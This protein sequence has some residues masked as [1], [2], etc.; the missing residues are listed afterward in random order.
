MTALRNSLRTGPQHARARSLAVLASIIGRKHGINVVFRNG[1]SASTDGKTIYL[2]ILSAN[3]SEEDAIL[4]EGLMD[5][6]AGHCRF[7]DFEFVRNNGVQAQLRSHALIFPTWNTFEDVWMEREQSKV[8]PG[9]FRNIKKSI[10][11]MIDRGLYAAPSEGKTTAADGMRGF[12]LH[13]LLGRLYDNKRMQEFGDLHREALVNVIGKSLTADIWQTALEIDSVK[14]TQDAFALALRIF[15]MIKSELANE[16][17][18]KRSSQ[19]K[20]DALDQILNIKPSGGDIGDMIQAALNANGV[21]DANPDVPQLT[22]LR[23]APASESNLL[24][25]PDLAAL[26]KPIASKLGSRLEV[27]LETKTQEATSFKRSGRKL[28]SGR[29]VGLTLGNLSAFVSREE[30]EGLDTAITILGDFSGSMYPILEEDDIHQ[31]PHVVTKTSMLAI[32]DVLERFEVPFSIIAYGND[33]WEIKSFEAP[34]RKSKALLNQDQ[35]GLTYTAEALLKVAERMALRKETR[36]LVLLLTDGDSRENALVIPAM[37]EMA[38]LGIE[39]ACIFIGASGT[40]LQ[41]LM[42]YEGYPVQRVSSIDALPQ[43]MF[44][45]IRNAV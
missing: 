17:Q 35:M 6:E 43:V 39:F 25:M 26:A 13:A 38:N 40:A 29:V 2:P 24:Y 12:L 22:Q 4:V 31:S 18:K 15:A 7:T 41:T 23:C 11:V 30:G 19:K 9:C 37:N 33:I 21:T 16:D 32:G 34:W 8:Y 28:A 1:A 5:H 45:A 42:T 10:E 14:T 36:K 27:L 20:K 44:E 3:A